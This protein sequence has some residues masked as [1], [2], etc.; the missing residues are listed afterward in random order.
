VPRE[1]MRAPSAGSDEGHRGFLRRPFKAAGRLDV[2]SA[3]WDDVP[4]RT[5]G[6]HSFDPL[7][8]KRGMPR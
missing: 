7:S 3:L 2:L 1:I 6:R 4:G 5:I 8:L